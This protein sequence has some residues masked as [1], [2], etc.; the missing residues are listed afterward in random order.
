MSAFLS[1]A[2]S[3]SLVGKFWFWQ[4]GGWCRNAQECLDRRDTY[5]GSSKHM[6][7]L[8]FS[9]ILGNQQS[10]NPGMAY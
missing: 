1:F 4:G 5:R 3:W 2:L 10:S 9:G 6:Q 7:P 8:S